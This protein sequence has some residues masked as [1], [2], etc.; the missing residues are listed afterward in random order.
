M[1]FKKKMRCLSFDSQ[2]TPIHIKVNVS[3]YFSHNHVETGREKL[4]E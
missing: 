3:T 1:I 4:F 2:R